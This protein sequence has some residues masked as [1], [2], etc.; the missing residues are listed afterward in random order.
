MGTR[1]RDLLGGALQSLRYE[2]TDKRV[3]IYLNEEPIA[4]TVNGLLVWEPRRVVPTYAVPERDV[5]ARLELVGRVDEL[6]DLPVLVPTNPFT[7]HSCTGEMLD[8]TVDTVRRPSAAF[9]PDDPDLTGYV[10]FDFSAFEWREEDEPIVAHPHDPFKRIDILASSRHVRVEWEGRLL[11]ESSR[12][13]LLF[14]TLL[15]VRFYLPRADV[16][17]DL[18]PTDTVSYCA[19]KGR[20]SYFSVPDGPADVAWTYHQP[21]REAEPVRDHTAFFN[22]RVNVI[23][24]GERRERPVTQWSG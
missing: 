8:V 24:D 3:R 7:A 1:M 9:R 13:L 16:V 10:T 6:A 12:P 20:A 22:E 18:E 2:P 17:I 23:V 5:S 19:Y 11:A 14:E 15:P 21:L 4:D